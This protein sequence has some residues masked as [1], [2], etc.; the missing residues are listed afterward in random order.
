MIEAVKL[1][2][3]K[4][5]LDTDAISENSEEGRDLT[6]LVEALNVV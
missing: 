4:L 3:I 2:L 6:A 1:K 5:I